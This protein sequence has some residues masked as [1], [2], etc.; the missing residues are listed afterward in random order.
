MKSKQKKKKTQV[1]KAHY[2]IRRDIRKQ[3]RGM[4][5]QKKVEVKLPD[6]K[7]KWFKVR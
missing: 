7:N 1:V 5:E 2:R 4:T 3:M 6:G